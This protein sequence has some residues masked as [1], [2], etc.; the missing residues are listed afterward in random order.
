MPALPRRWGWR[1]APLSGDLIVK[2]GRSIAPRA[3]NARAANRGKCYYRGQTAGGERGWRE[4]A[5]IGG[6]T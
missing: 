2:R 3:A 1:P 5:D 4:L 6:T